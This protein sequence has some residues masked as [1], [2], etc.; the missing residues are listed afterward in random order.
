[1]AVVGLAINGNYDTIDGMWWAIVPVALLNQNFSV[2]KGTL[3]APNSSHVPGT[4]RWS[5]DLH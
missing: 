2:A 4:H 3:S 5:S 1:M